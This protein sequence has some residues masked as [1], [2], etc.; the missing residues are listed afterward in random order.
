MITIQQAV[1]QIIKSRPFLEESLAEMCIRLFGF[2]Q[3]NP[4]LINPNSL[5]SRSFYSWYLMN[6]RRLP[7]DHTPVP[8]MSRGLIIKSASSRSGI[9]IK[10]GSD[11]SRMIIKPSE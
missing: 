3:Y 9:N 7:V 10:S 5:A 11:R 2:F 1:G 6:R 8:T 4:N